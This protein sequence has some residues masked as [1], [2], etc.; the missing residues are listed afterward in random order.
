MEIHSH[1]KLSTFEQCPLKYKLKYID[2]VPPEIEKTI[3]A[4]LGSIIHK[5]FEWI[6]NSVK[7]LKKSPALDEI[8]TYYSVKW[9]EEFSKEILIVKKELNETD[10][11]QKGI[12]FL[13]NYFKENYPFKDGT[14]E[15]EKR[16]IINLDEN[17]KILG[18]I[19]RLVYNIKTKEY[20]IHDY[21]TS[22][23][24]PSQEKIE[25]DRQLA[26]YSIAIKE[27]YG[28]DKEVCLIWHYLAHNQKICLK[29]TNEQLNKIKEETIDLI[30]KIEKTN[31]FYG[32]TSSLCNWCEYKKVCPVW[33]PD[34]PHTTKLN[35]S[36]K[37]LNQKID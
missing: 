24:L 35:K 1:S 30:K 33:N 16:I 18:F 3:E 37:D 12:E 10:Y 23:T 29:K 25:S 9:Q 5:T 32:K 15:C 22:N 26:L 28:Y 17:T 20:E 11:F 7:E 19:D 21:K 14:I 34:S 2:K 8:I 6:Y 36:K 13:I 27:L 4:H 31:E